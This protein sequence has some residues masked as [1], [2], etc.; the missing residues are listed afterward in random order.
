MIMKEFFLYPFLLGVFFCQFCCGETLIWSGK[1]NS[2]GKPT[3]SI[4]LEL[5]KKYRLQVTGEINLG[6]WWQ[7]RHPLASD[8]CY[9]FSDLTTPPVRTKINTFKN[10]LDVS[11]CDGT[12]N[13]DHIY[14]SSVFTAAQTGIHFWV[15]D[16]N[17]EDNNG[18]FDAQVFEVTEGK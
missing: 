15:Y 4:K 11:V 7:Q 16:T 17:Y 2:N 10:S 5:G 13:A 3:E 8:A 9:E 18:E 6:K 14:K 1:V 12:Y